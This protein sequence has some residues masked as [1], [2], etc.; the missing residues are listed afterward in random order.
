[1]KIAPAHQFF[2]TQHQSLAQEIWYQ[3]KQL[4]H[5]VNHSSLKDSSHCMNKAMR[6]L[7]LSAEMHDRRKIL[8]F[9]FHT[10][11]YFLIYL[12][13]SNKSWWTITKLQHQW[14]QYILHSVV[15]SVKLVSVRFYKKCIVRQDPH[16]TESV[17]HGFYK[18]RS[19]YPKIMKNIVTI[20][21]YND[22]FFGEW[23]SLNYCW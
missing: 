13:L 10:Y 22:L 5:N 8:K 16:K 17:T 12:M 20:S 9:N 21:Y 3:G 18:R 14:L 4:V 23:D 11:W 19:F 1:M 6:Y 15:T 7:C 2:G